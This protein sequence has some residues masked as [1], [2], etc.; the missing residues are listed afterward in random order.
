MLYTPAPLP[1]SLSPPLSTTLSLF[2][3]RSLSPC[4]FFSIPLPFSFSLSN[5]LPLSLT[6]SLTL[7]LAE[8]I[9][10]INQCCY[11]WVVGGEAGKARRQWYLALINEVTFPTAPGCAGDKSILFSK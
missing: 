1:P 4:L 7:Y 3:S 10:R 6:L 2:S 11:L 8:L 5:S 9:I